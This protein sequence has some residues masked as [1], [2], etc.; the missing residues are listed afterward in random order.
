VIAEKHQ[1]YTPQCLKHRLTARRTEHTCNTIVLIISYL[2]C[3]AEGALISA[4]K[5]PTF[6]AKPPL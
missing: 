2:S 1:I 6:P 3:A 4:L 5:S